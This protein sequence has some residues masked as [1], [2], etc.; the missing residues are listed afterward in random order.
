MLPRGAVDKLP[1]MRS[2]NVGRVAE[3][4]RRLYLEAETADRAMLASL[5]DAGEGLDGVISRMVAAES[6]DLRGLYRTYANNFLSV[7]PD[8]GRFLYMCAR[9]CRARCIVEFGTSMGI[10]TIHLATALRDMG[11]GRVIGTELES[12]KV[13][14][15]QVN[16]ESAGLA[17]LVEIRE[18]DARETL[19]HIDGEVDLVLLDGAFTLYLPVLK[20]LEPRLRDGAMI[21]AENAFEKAGGYLEYVRD[22]ANGYMSRPIPVNE[23]RGNELSVFVRSTAQVN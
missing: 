15:A 1:S 11:G 21:L 12:S 18:G 4:L 3:T 5:I 19:R 2:L 13:V 14:L 22:P 17:D 20:V 16:L 23:G 10:S 9:A 6:Q 7:S 8:F